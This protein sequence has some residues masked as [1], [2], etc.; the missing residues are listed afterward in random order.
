MDFSSG[1]LFTYGDKENFWNN[2]LL[3]L[4]DLGWNE[5]IFV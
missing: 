1:Y 3:F 2:A 4:L 5:Y